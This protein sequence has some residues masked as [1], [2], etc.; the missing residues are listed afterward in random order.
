MSLAAA[1][2]IPSNPVAKAAGFVYHEG[3]ADDRQNDITGIES[4]VP[5]AALSYIGVL[6]LIP[7]ISGAVRDPFVQFHAKQGIV[8]FAGM[9]LAIIASIWISYV[10]AGLFLLMLVASVA[11]LFY[12]LNKDEWEIP[13]ISMIAGLFSL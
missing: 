12:A 8:I 4:R 13:G 6:V 11:G 7:I 3:M 2:L 1:K 5:M 9:V 10:G